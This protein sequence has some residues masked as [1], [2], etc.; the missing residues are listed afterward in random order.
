M[1][2]KINFHSR[3]RIKF[4]YAIILHFIIDI[5][6]GQRN[7]RY[8]QLYYY[9]RVRYTNIMWTRDCDFK[10]Q[11]SQNLENLAKHEPRLFLLSLKDSVRRVNQKIFNISLIY[12]FLQDIHDI[13]L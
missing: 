8:F 3:R 9:I 5:V 11:A 6:L 13:S 4:V 10:D 1:V 12:A 7:G 2:Y